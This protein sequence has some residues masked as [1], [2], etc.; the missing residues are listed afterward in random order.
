MY[1]NDIHESKSNN[2]KYVNC[3]AYNKGFYGPKIV[4]ILMAGGYR[5]EW[6]DYKDVNCTKEQICLT[7]GNYL[8]TEALM[9]GKDNEQTIA[10]KV[11]DTLII[12]RVI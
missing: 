2:Y 12:H 7:L 6:W 3:Q 9:I 8:S 11:R 10:M 1:F 4:W 5:N